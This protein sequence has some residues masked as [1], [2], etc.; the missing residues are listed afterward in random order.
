VSEIIARFSER[1]KKVIESTFMVS[2]PE[3]WSH[4]LANEL[5]IS[6]NALRQ[7]RF[8]IKQKLRHELAQKGVSLNL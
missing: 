7:L 5:G 6:L 8:R 3:R 2:D 4:D 1:E